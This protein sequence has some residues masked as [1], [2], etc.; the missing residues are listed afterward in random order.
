MVSKF[1]E[2]LPD[3]DL[4]MNPLDQPRVV[5]PWNDLQ[6]HLQKE[7]DSRQLPTDS[8]DAY[9]KGMKG[10][11][12]Q[13]GDTS[14]PEMS[15]PAWFQVSGQEFMKVAKEACPPGSHA[16][17]SYF[18]ASKEQAE[19]LYKE[20]TGGFITNYNRSSDLCVVGPEIE[21]KHGLLYAPSMLVTT[22]L[23]VPVFGECKTNVNNDILFPA[24]MYYRNDER[25]VYDAAEDKDWDAKGD[26][27]IWRGVTSGGVN[28]AENWRH[29]HR[30]RLALLTN[31]TELGDDVVRITTADYKVRGAY[32][33]LERFKP[34]DFAKKYTDVAFG[35]T[36][37]CWPDCGFFKS[38][39]TLVPS[40]S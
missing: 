35:L 6:K 23:L 38:I 37:D 7:V 26:K 4:A 11:F 31:S 34:K 32:Q 8:L 28:T 21:D 9:T 12:E 27:A 17:A 13:E 3:M 22:R 18:S 39:W 16:R 40:E 33:S 20:P 25:Y 30:S 10:F 36:T 1:V 14:T 2:Y 19:R 5:V 15:D 29:L 24:N